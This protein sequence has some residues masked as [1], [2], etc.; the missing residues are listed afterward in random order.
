MDMPEIGRTRLEDGGRSVAGRIIKLLV[1]VVGVILIL[2]FIVYFSREATIIARWKSEGVLQSEV[3]SRPDSTY[4]FMRVDSTDFV[5]GPI[6]SAGN[7]LYKIEDSAAGPS[8]WEKYF[9]SPQPVGKDISIEYIGKADTVKSVVRLSRVRT[10][11]FAAF[12]SMALLRFL[13]CASYLAVGLWAFAKRPNS[14]A[15]R[16]L[17]LF[18]F[19]MSAFL[20]AGI[21][22]GLDNYASFSIPYLGIIR[23]VL[24]LFAIFFGSFWLNLQLLFPSP[25]KFMRDHSNLGHIVCYAPIALLLSA[26]FL[27]K[28][29]ALGLIVILWVALQIG[30][31]L[32]ILARSHLSSTALLE[33]RQTRLVLWGSGIGLG[34]LIILFTLAIFAVNW[35]P[36]IPQMFMMGILSVT[37][38]A[39]FLSP[40]SFAYSFGRYRLLEIEGRIRRGT[41]YFVVTLTLLIL[42]YGLIYLF[43][44]FVLEITGVASRAPTLIVALLLAI[45]FTPTRRRIQSLL[46]RKMYPERVRLREMLSDF[47]G[48][49]LTVTD[50]KIFWSELEGKLKFILRV[51][52]I[53]PVLRGAGD[54]V[55]IGWNDAATPFMSEGDFIGKIAKLG[56]HP[57]MR[58]ELEAS[59]KVE[60]TEPERGWLNSNRIALILPMV[61]RLKL[62]G[63]L[64]IGFKSE[65]RDFEVADFEILQSLASQVAVAGENIM[66]LEESAEK[67]RLETELSIARKVQE[68]MLP[69]DMPSTPGLEVGALS[70]FCTEVAGDYYDIIQLGPHRTAMAIGDVSGKGAG[71]ALL[72]SNVQASF[73]TAVGIESRMADKSMQNRGKAES[74]SVLDEFRLQDVIGN[75]NELICRNSQPE[76]FITFFVCIYDN[77]RKSLIYVN[78]GHNLPLLVRKEGKIEELGEGGLILGAMPGVKY[79]Q[80]EVRM[81][82]GD[83][84]FLYTDGASE[85]G[86]ADG[87]MYGEEKLKRFLL[88]NAEMNPNELLHALEENVVKFGGDPK[89]ADDFTLLAARVTD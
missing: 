73:R 61:A 57:I 28:G 5:S 74:D 32:L 70:R 45:G 55:F 1:A 25:K 80:G 8:M 89:L 56:N 87:E 34:A 62:I 18:C 10:G 3:F 21:Q 51:D 53:Y 63:F 7:L 12:L 11:Y 71:A 84:L 36:R 39:L 82:K 77:E 64:G 76:Q 24:G 14:G 43:S 40:L 17:A 42:F 69:H 37:F 68:G 6:P 41:R 35:I 26:G 29:S 13:I 88:E 46:E 9:D 22:M 59:Q 23:R 33:R 48:N 47:L 27:M 49:S 67:R 2:V 81:N 72:M 79:D 15:V 86:N 54:G 50:K 58:D 85:A 75:I 60:L 30:A 83:L 78:A 4:E 19:S 38:L 65:Q 52:T 66:L 44:E 16:A 20:L 31:G